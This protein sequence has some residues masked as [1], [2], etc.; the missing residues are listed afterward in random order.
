MSTH[1]TRRTRL[2]RTAAAAAAAV[3]ALVLPLGSAPAQAS[4]AP[5]AQRSAAALPPGVVM[6]L[7]GAPCPPGTLCLYR[8]YGRSGPAYGIGAGYQVDLRALP[9]FGSGG[10]SAANNVSSWVNHTG[11]VALLIDTDGQRIRPLLPGQPLEEPPFTN[12]SVDI[13]SWQH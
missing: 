12:D 8:D 13:V 5:A 2:A 11:G 9:M 6:L 7:D 1:S 4:A 10:P 3:A